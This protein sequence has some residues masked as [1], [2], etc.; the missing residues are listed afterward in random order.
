MMIALADVAQSAPLD[1]VAAAEHYAVFGQLLLPFE[2]I[3]VGEPALVGA[4]ASDLVAR[5]EADGFDYRG[6]DSADHLSAELGYVQ[7]LS[8]KGRKERAGEFVG[9][10]LGRWLVALCVPLARHGGRFAPR[11]DELMRWIY[12][13]VAAGAPRAYE[14]A[15][16]WSA[17]DSAGRAAP[18]L[19]ARETDLRAIV[20]YLLTPSRSG[21]FVSAADLRHIA[22]RAGVPVG[23]GAR[24][25]LLRQLLEQAASFERA[26]A[27]FADLD[28]LFGEVDAAY[29]DYAA[30]FTRCDAN[31]WRARLARTRALC[32]RIG[33]EAR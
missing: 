14:T 3:F 20:D 13:D 15:A 16:A 7:F 29:A 4:T 23:M 19:D 12:D 31:D 10:H 11:A 18:D 6:Y 33:E 25:Q 8:A 9:A 32:A 27:V 24:A 30:R 21:L 17:L 2:G 1:D 26:P 28:V 22:R 5:Y